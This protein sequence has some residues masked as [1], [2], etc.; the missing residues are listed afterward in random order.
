MPSNKLADLTN[1]LGIGVSILPGITVG[2]ATV[3]GA[4]WVDGTNTVQPGTGVFSRGA[5][6]GAPTTATYT[7]TV[8][9]ADDSS[10]TNAQVVATQ[11]TLVLTATGTAQ[12]GMVR[13]HQT[14]PYHRARIVGLH[15]GGST[16]SSQITAIIGTA[17]QKV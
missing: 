17:K 7:C 2:D 10:G 15:V 6:S 4:V 14:K 5:V 16:P 1:L 8:W 9:E 11:S 12:S 13:F 3:D